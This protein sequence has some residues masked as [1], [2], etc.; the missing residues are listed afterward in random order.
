M[1]GQRG[2]PLLWRGGCNALFDLESTCL[3]QATLLPSVVFSGFADQAWSWP[4]S[5]AAVSRIL[6]FTATSLES[7]F[8]EGCREVTVV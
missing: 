8:L 5:V 7:Q 2:G 6:G 1:P 4:L 3:S